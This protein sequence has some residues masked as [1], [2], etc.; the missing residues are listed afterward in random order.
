MSTRPQLRALLIDLSG[1]LHVGN[2][3][4]PGAVHA[5][6]RLRAAKIP[7]RFCSNTSKES[8]ESIRKRLETMGFSGE[9]GIRTE[10]LWTS[11]GAIGGVLKEKG[12]QRW[13]TTMRIRVCQLNISPLGHS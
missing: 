11:I 12:I 8:T 9:G 3:P 7:F 5:L 1:T 10:E 6:A 4:T 13:M 2:D